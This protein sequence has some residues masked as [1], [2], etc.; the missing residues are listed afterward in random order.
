MVLGAIAI[1]YFALPGLVF[2][3]DVARVEKTMSPVF[4]GMGFQL[5]RPPAGLAE[6]FK[7]LPTLRRTSRWSFFGKGQSVIAWGI[8]EKSHGGGIRVLWSAPH[9]ALEK[10]WVVGSKFHKGG[11]GKYGGS[12]RLPVWWQTPGSW[13]E[14]PASVDELYRILTASIPGQVRFGDSW[15]IAG[16]NGW[17]SATREFNPDAVRFAPHFDSISIAVDGARLN[18]ATIGT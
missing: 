13:G 2:R 12:L 17:L 11:P 8:I 10:T 3:L 7:G 16:G 6:H 14:I 9:H 15:T 5:M 1:V 4:K 18:T